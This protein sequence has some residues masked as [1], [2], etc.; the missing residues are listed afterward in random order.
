MAAAAALLAVACATG[1]MAQ[2]APPPPAAAPADVPQARRPAL[3]GYRPFSDEGTT[4]WPQANETVLRA[5]GWRAYAR[6]AA[7]P[8]ASPAA[9]SPTP[10]SDAADPH[11][12]HHRP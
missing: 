9:S 2:T 1:G 6:E 12:G 4:S 11:A 7:Q 5:G 3:E 10:R 8:A